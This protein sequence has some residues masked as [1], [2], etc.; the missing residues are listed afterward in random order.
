MNAQSKSLLPSLG[1]GAKIIAAFVV[2]LLVVVAANYVV[3]LGGYRKDI[4]RSMIE[5]A[6]VMTAVAQ[7]AQAG[8]SEKFQFG[9]V[10][11]EE[12][13]ADALEH[14][15]EGGHYKDTRFFESIPVVV[16]WHNAEDA[17]R[18]EGVV[19]EVV[20]LEAR[21]PENA[22]EPGSFRERL[23][24]D[25]TR[26]HHEQGGGAVIHRVNEETNTLHYMRAITLDQSCMTCHG[27]PAVYDT[28][29]ENG[30]VDGKDL[31]GFRMENWPVGYMH[32]AYEVQMPLDITDAQ[33]AGFFKSGM[34]VTVPVLLVAG[35]AGF[36]GLRALLSK[37]LNGLV[38][39]VKEVATGDGDL[40]RRMNL[41]RR[42]EIGR[43]GYWFD[44]FMSSLNGIICEIRDCTQQ[45]ASASTEI[46]A[47]AEQMSCGLQ[48]QEEQ[49]QQV[50]AAVE[51][52]SHS[53]S[54]V[55]AKST[56][57]TAA[58]EESQRLAE[59]GG[60]IVSGTVETMQGIATEVD[61]SARTV[62]SLGE[63]SEKIGDIISVIN[64]IADQT[65]LL[66]LNAAIEAARAGEHG[67]G[68][69]VVADEVRKLAERTQTATEEV[70]QS[71]RGIQSET[72]SAVTR[73][74]SG[75]DRVNEGVA[76][77]TNA[78]ESLTT[79]VESSKAL[80]SMVQGIAAAA[81]EQSAASGEIARSVEGI[82]AVTRE[83]TEGAGQAAMAAADLARQAESLQGL[84]GKF[85]TA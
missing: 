41:S 58:A 16:G 53:V 74:E 50:A 55:A 15:E 85:K 83:S 78:G 12:L 49:T 54:E 57:A 44:Q 27:D 59:E 11:T 14:I 60:D 84:V 67:R 26:L 30:Y 40:C 70:S 24:E 31:L 9:E 73:I 80:Q 8:A 38:A 46:A 3:F 4:Q 69:A 5:K 43:L 82:N 62:N 52:M 63:Q 23:I 56:D 10:N 42:D 77:A 61:A 25:L 47:S 76:L 65:N 48:T 18:Q 35:V 39:M 64:D 21:N 22:P 28:P 2:I 7:A 72:K 17:A 33:V 68:F 6:S 66:A 1:L 81:N 79:I 45:V 20:S 37:P 71:I 13:I 32:G 75:S 51:Q 29:D 19:F 36:F 34:K